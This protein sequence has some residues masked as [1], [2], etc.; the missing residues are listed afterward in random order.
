MRAFVNTYIEEGLDTRRVLGR[1]VSKRQLPEAIHSPPPL[2]GSNARALTM[3][4]VDAKDSLKYKEKRRQWEEG[5]GS[6]SWFKELQRRR[7][8]EFAEC[9]DAASSL[10]RRLDE[11]GCRLR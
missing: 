5:K 9:S 8:V 2:H 3:I 7:V 6:G 11:M 4:D 10:M 1:L